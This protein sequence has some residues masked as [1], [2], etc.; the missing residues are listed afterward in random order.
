MFA[1]YGLRVGDKTVARFL[2]SRGYS[3]Q[4]AQ[5]T[6]EGKQHPDRDGQFEYINANAQE[7]L[8]QGIQFI[9]VDTTKKELVGDFKNAGREWQP[10]GEP[11]NVGVHDF[12]GDAV[13]KAI[14][15]GVYDVAA[16][17]AFVTVG[18]DHDRAYPTGKRV[19]AKEMSELNLTRE[20][21]HGDWNYVL[22]PRP[23]T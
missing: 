6:V 4:P 5:K 3:L 21:F 2:R 18:V 13:G 22:S 11:E 7:C 15:Y 17:N 9:S 12:P 10:K 19:S 1:K 16:N 20:S 8:A 14:P 23:N